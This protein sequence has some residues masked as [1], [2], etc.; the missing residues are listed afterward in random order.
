VSPTPSPTPRVI[1]FDDLQLIQRP[2][3]GQYPG[4]IADWGANVWY[5]SGPYHQF[6]TNSVSFNGAGPT[7]GAI[8]LLTPRVP[9]Q[10]D[11]DNGGTAPTTV[12][13]TCGSNPQV[14][15]TVG[16]RQVVT[17]TT[18]WTSPCSSLTI[19]SSTGWDSN[20]DNFVLQ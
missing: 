16:A 6:G 5:L 19:A 20:F 4:G 7:S 14:S 18:G 11:I 3:N 13:L 2:L 15:M 10:L 9:R 1:T 8:T 17:F 12:T